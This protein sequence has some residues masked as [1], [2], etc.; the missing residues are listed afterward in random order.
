M[1]AKSSL[2]SLTAYYC[3]TTTHKLY[4]TQARVIASLSNMRFVKEAR[5]HF[6]IIIL[7]IYLQTTFAILTSITEIKTAD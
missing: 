4:I 1:C 7:P 5:Y 6:H 2:K 3:L